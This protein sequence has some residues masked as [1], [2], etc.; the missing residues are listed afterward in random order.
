MFNCIDAKPTLKEELAAEKEEALRE[1]KYEDYVAR[2]SK[3]SSGNEH[4]PLWLLR[5]PQNISDICFSQSRFNFKE[6]E[7][8]DILEAFECDVF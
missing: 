7:D 8:E 4:Q 6:L 5:F 1:R 2:R 3:M